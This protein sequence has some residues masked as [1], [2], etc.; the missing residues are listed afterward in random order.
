MTWSRAQVRVSANVNAVNARNLRA[1]RKEAG[2]CVNGR[3]MATNGC[4]C[5]RCALVYGHGA[6][7]AKLMDDYNAAPLCNP[8]K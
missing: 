3:A 8:R 4:R 5:L 6:A 2:T 7:K 1:V